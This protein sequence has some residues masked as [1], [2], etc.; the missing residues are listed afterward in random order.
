MATLLVGIN[1]FP[2]L[3]NVFNSFRHAF[4]QVASILT[5]TGFAST[6]FNLFP[7]FSQHIL[8]LLMV[9]G[10]CAGSTAG[11]L[12][13]SRVIVLCKSFLQE[14]KRL[15]H[16]H[17]VTVVRLE[18][19]ALEKSTL[20][21]TLSYFAMYIMIICVSTLLISIDGFDLTTN[22]TAVLSCINNIGPGLGKVGPMS[23]FGEYSAFSK[24]LLSFDML[25]GR[26]EILPMLVLFTPA[27]WRKK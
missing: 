15:F 6:D 12:K 10:A 1:I 17:A 5:T 8:V 20:R 23:N 9:L 4:F 19:K 26:L 18:G 7:A 24:I 13:I 14:I 22:L 16:P 27:A 21:G 3:D 2:L 11:G 25:L